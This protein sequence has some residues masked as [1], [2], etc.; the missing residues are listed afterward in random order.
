MPKAKKPAARKRPRRPVRRRRAPAAARNRHAV[1]VALAALAH[2]I[3]TPLTGILAMSE[4]LVASEL[5]ERERKWAEGVQNAAEHLAQLT[6]IVVDAVKEDAAGLAIRRDVFSP[7]KLAETLAAGLQARAEAHGLKSSFAAAANLPAHVAG[8]PVRIRAAI[9]NLFDNAVKFTAKGRVAF[10]VTSEK[11]GKKVRLVFTVADT[12]AGLS[13][14]ELKTLFRPFVQGTQVASGR[15]AGS[16]LGLAL[17]KR[18]ARA[19]GGDLTAES[20]PGR[21]TT[22]TLGIAVEPAA[23]PAQ[24]AAS[25]TPAARANALRVLCVEDN[26]YGRVVL[27]TILKELGHRVDFASSGEAA[28]DAVARGGYDLVLM[29]VTLSGIDGFET[30]RR[31]RRLPQPVRDVAILGV[32]ARTSPADEAVALDA[33]MDGY[34]RK[35]VSPAALAQEIAKVKVR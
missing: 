23:A 35:P 16:G 6:T 19:M 5:G 7:R 17:V 26:P 13:T 24:S 14:G 20:E 9:E 15:A 31:I 11:A 33:G 25:A 32:S 21:G 8:D 3:R 10:S 12:G 30:T 28:I 18:L 34:L 29:D 1:E 2:D 27:N 22:F 4:L